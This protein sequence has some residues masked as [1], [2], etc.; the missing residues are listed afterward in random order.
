M[1]HNGKPC[2]T[3]VV[4]FVPWANFLWTLEVSVRE[5]EIT[6]QKWQFIFTF[7]VSSLIVQQTDSHVVSAFPRAHH[8]VSLEAK[9]ETQR[10]SVRLAGHFLSGQSWD[11]VNLWFVRTVWVLPEELSRTLIGKMISLGSNVLSLVIWKAGISMEILDLVIKCN[12]LQ[13]C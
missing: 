13:P 2:T 1:S 7:Q 11:S 6:P 12:H 9:F 10:H 8:Q 3:P 5:R 4:M